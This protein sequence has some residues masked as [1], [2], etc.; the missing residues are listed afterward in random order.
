MACNRDIFTL[1]YFTYV[2]VFL[3]VSFLLAFTPIS[4]MHFFSSPFV[5]HALHI[6]SSLTIKFI[7][8]VVYN[9]S[10]L[11]SYLSATDPNRL[12]LFREIIA[13]YCENH[14]EHDWLRT[15]RLRGRGSS[16]GMVK[17]FHFSMSS[18]PALGSTQPLIQWVPEALS[19]NKT[20]GA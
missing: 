1:L 6:S 19:R 8:I 13:V 2:L 18:R 17:N 5:L 9:Y 4:Y 11:C 3:V 15:G 12:M 20:A 16:P 7:Y 14:T 10:N